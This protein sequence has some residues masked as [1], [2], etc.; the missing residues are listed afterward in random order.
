[1]RAPVLVDSGGWIAEISRRDQHH[2][3]SVAL[4]RRAVEERTPLV[5]TNLIVAEVYRQLLHRAGIRVA[6]RVLELVEMSRLL[7]LEFVT[8]EHHRRARD[9]LQRLDDQPLTYTDAVSF[10]VMTARRCRFVLGF[11]HHF[12]IAGFELWRPTA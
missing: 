9:W 4:F 8:A 2:E 7:T 10:A 5:T 12:E 1:V 11:D 3:T 6:R